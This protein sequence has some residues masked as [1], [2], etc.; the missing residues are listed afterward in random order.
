ME[1]R[2]VRP[3]W[4]GPRRGQAEARGEAG[5]R[6]RAATG[7][8]AAA[9]GG[10]FLLLAPTPVLAQSL[11]LGRVVDGETGAPVAGASVVLES[12][13]LQGAARFA[14]TTD[15]DGRFRIEEL[16]AGRYQLT[17]R[18]LAWADVERTLQVAG[19]G[20]VTEVAVELFRELVSV[21]PIVV[22]VDP[23]PTFGPLGEVYQRMEHMERLGQGRFWDREAIVASGTSRLTTLLSTMV[24]VRVAGGNVL[25]TS[26]PGRSAGA[27]RCA[28]LLFVNGSP[29]PLRGESLD[30]VVPLSDLEVVEV[31]RRPS[32]L[33]AEYSGSDARCG[34]IAVW[35]R[36]G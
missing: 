11:V 6:R 23:R 10:L 3:R 18:H 24:G 34:V 20:R 29:F 14:A 30:H 12:G 36:R 31:Y 5:R 1:G 4:G 28:P 15:A 27:S 13:V 25:L 7:I 2:P 26:T 19:G 21:S 35:T 17:V 16:E 33:P 32:E 22:R 8:L 9:C